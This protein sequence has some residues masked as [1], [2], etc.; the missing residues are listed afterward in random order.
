[1]WQECLV[2]LA[3]SHIPNIQSHSSVAFF[4]ADGLILLGNVTYYITLPL[5]SNVWVS[6][7]CKLNGCKVKKN[8]AWVLNKGILM[9]NLMQS[10]SC[11]AISIMQWHLY[12]A[13]QSLYR[14]MQSLLSNAIYIKHR[15]PFPLFRII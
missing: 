3:W 13:M 1:M 14:A 9:N 12:H 15:L 8:K 5:K 7:G 10:L 11:N 6:L 2:T 4:C